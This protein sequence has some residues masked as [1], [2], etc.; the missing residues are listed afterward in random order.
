[1]KKRI[2]FTLA[3]ITC[4]VL[5]TTSVFATDANFNI[6]ATIISNIAVTTAQNLSFPVHEAV[7]SDT[8]V[9]VAPGDTTAAK[10][11][12]TGE[13]GKNVT[14]SV[15]DSSIT[16]TCSTG[17]CNGDTITVNGFSLGGDMSSSGA[18]TFNNSGQLNNLLVGAT[19]T[20]TNTDKPGD[21]SGSATFRLVYS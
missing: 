11:T 7:S 4:S 20:L 1:M 8:P 14:G 16:L 12:A 10:F 6:S 18:A 17:A 19:E 9:V 13:A 2:L 3:S 5:I 15:T 21:Y